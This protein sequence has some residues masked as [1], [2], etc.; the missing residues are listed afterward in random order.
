MQ[1]DSVN[2]VLLPNSKNVNEDGNEI[3]EDRY[4]G[5]FLKISYTQLISGHSVFANDRVDVEPDGSFRF[6]IPLK[7]ELAD[8]QVK[9][10]VYAPD[11]E[12]LGTKHDSYGSL[13]ASHID[14]SA[15][16]ETQPYEIKVNPKSNDVALLDPVVSGHRKIRG[17]VIDLAAEHST[18]GLQVIVMVSDDPG[19]DYDGSTYQPLFSATTDSGGYFFGRIPNVAVQRAFG[20]I[21]GLE[22]NP[23]ALPLETGYLPDD[24]LLVADLSDLPETT[25]SPTG[26]P[27][28]PDTDDLVRSGEYSQDIGGTCVNFTVPNRTLEE[29]SFYH[30]VRTTEPEIRGLTIGASQTGRI[31]KEL[32]NLSDEM[33]TL[34]GKLNNSFKSLSVVEYAVD[35]SKEKVTAVD[36]GSG[37][38]VMHL[39][40][41]ATASESA[42]AA[43]AMYAAPV[44]N[45]KV[46][47]GSSMLKLKSSDILEVSKGVNFSSLIKILA[48]QQRRR[49]KLNALHRKLAAAYCGKNGVQEA[50]SYC[51]SLKAED[52]LN[53]DTVAS[54]LGHFREYTGVIKP[55]TKIVKQF[56]AHLSDLEALIATPFADAEAI[57]VVEKNAQKLVIAIDKGIA[58]TEDQ[59]ELLEYLR[60]LVVELDHAAEATDRGF[61]PCPPAEAKDTMGILCLIQAFEQTREELKNKAVFSL[62]EILM[63]RANYDTFLNSIAAFLNLLDEFHTFYKSGKLFML[64]LEDNYFIEHYDTVKNT[65]VSLKRQIFRAID[66]IEKIEHDYITNHPGRRELSV[67]TS[68]DW[69]DTPTVY[70]NTTIAHGHILHFKQKW[71]ADGY[72]LGDLLYS[73]PLAPCQE[74]QIAILEWDREESTARMEGQTVT[75][76]MQAGISR[77]RDI[78]EIMNSSMSENIHASSTNKTGSTSAGIGGGLG[79]FLSGVTFG[80]VGGVS[81][82]GAS[83]KSTADQNASRNLSGS[84]L[85]R[86]QDNISQSA[87]AVRSQRNTVVQSVGQ[88]E[89]VRAQTEVIK[90]NNHCHAMT[91]QYFEVLKH[92]A[93]EQELVDVQECLFVPLPMS[94]FDH[95]KV[96]RWSDALRRSLYG[97]KLQRGIDAI[98]RIESHYA[99]SDFPTGAYCDQP[100]EEFTGSFS[101]SFDLTRPYISEIDEA[102]K[103]EVYD[104]T[105]PFPWFGRKIVISMERD[106]PLTEAEK[107]ALFEAEYAP[108]IVR[109]FI[110]RM[111]VTA[112]A[113]DGTETPLDLDVTLMSHYRKGAPLQVN[114][115]SASVHA[116]TRRQIKHL[117][118]GAKTVVTASS[119][120]ILRTAYLHYRTK[121]LSE[122]IVRNGRV[123]NDIMNSREVK[124]DFAEFPFFKFETHTDAALLYTPMNDR[125]TRDPRKEDREAAQQLIAFLNEHL[126]MSHKVIWAGMDSSRLFGLL[127]GYIAPNTN[128]RSVASVVENRIM[129]IVGNNLILKVVPGERID[130]V[131]RKVP[132]LLEYYRPTT[133]PDPFRISVPTKGVYA[134]SVMGA[135]NSCEEI[136]DARHWRFE[137]VPCGTTPTAINA[138]STDSRRSDP[139]NLQ[140]KDLPTNIIAMQTAPSEPDPTGLAAAYTAI[141]KSDLFKDMT[142]LAGTQSNALQALQTTSKSVTDLASKAA[143]IQKQQAMQKDISK[144]LKTI[145]QAET[146]KQIDKTQAQ[147]L[148][149]SALSTMVGESTKKKENLSKQEEVKKAITNASQNKQDITIKQGDESVTITVPKTCTTTT[150]PTN[151]NSGSTNP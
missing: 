24:L 66:R 109:G 143:E 29:F 122:Y 94:D 151:T 135:C 69:D 36:T 37:N 55:D 62:G 121:H 150:T 30:T 81:H 73:L 25:F 8:E 134:E 58:P 104:L 53:R 118:F 46:A 126:E 86:L 111:E 124:I 110:D 20:V 68:I 78:S 59:R 71:K 98:E 17:R 70:E 48:E 146:D 39:T 130:P 100:I 141:A 99:N 61:E 92:Y 16:D 72:S 115:T 131:F 91:V 13:Y 142:G 27:A 64:S 41:N 145:K 84:T 80:L 14:E 102:M 3:T 32:L 117:R 119:K 22:S 113:D 96:L 51:D 65:L 33:F 5:H 10:D 137:D 74:K 133:R 82:S 54:L 116:I 11:G 35:E 40:T 107:D 106:V 15:A 21:A 28:Q 43:A 6:F 120:I 34:F 31:K 144:T 18:A 103:T 1:R 128:G 149:Y 63:I 125:E 101:L 2:G 57:G 7:T 50:Q 114:I 45:L 90:N 12:L 139:G 47:T 26:T 108:D 38:T 132:E 19:A 95:A 83:S 56:M 105:I 9:V 77:D 42:T 136:D 97:R 138:L 75:E 127:D 49:D 79:G 85:N 112:I 23:I 88:H 148:T 147:K 52:A 87:S 44:Y 67:E 93:L 129:G 140:V 60:R 76:A 89:S 4:R 123:N